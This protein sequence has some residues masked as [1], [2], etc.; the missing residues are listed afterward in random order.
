MQGVPSTHADETGQW[1][2]GDSMVRILGERA[3]HGPVDMDGPLDRGVLGQSLDGT[4]SAGDD[5]HH[6]LG[7]TPPLHLLGQFHD[8]VATGADVDGMHHQVT[9]ILQKVQRLR[10]GHGALVDG[11]ERLVHE[12]LV[13]LGI[14]QSPGTG[15][16]DVLGG[17]LGIETY[18]GLHDGP[19]QGLLGTSKELP[20]ALCAEFR[21]LE[22]GID[23]IGEGH[24]LQS[25][26][27]EGTQSEQV[28]GDDAEDLRNG[29]HLHGKILHGELHDD[30][31]PF[32]RDDACTERV[33]DL[34]VQGRDACP[35]PGGLLRGECLGG[36]LHGQV[37]GHAVFAD[38]VFVVVGFLIKMQMRFLCHSNHSS[39]NTEYPS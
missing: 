4:E 11:A 22:L 36:L 38:D 33:E 16:V 24:V 13:V 3:V 20:D 32:D 15:L 25:D 5:V 37:R 30:L 26:T 31:V 19:H 2:H 7:G 21:T 1:K 29:T 34:V 6:E 17:P 23:G 14:G 39:P 8:P 12:G 27:L 9:L 28:P 10:D 18:L 35:C